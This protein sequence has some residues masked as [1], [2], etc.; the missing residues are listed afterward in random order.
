MVVDNSPTLADFYAHVVDTVASCSFQ[1][2]A[3]TN[4]LVLDP[5]CTVHPFNGASFCFKCFKSISGSR[6]EFTSML[7]DRLTAVVQK[8]R[9]MNAIKQDTQIYAYIQYGHARMNTEHSLLC[10][11][12][13]SQVGLE[14]RVSSLDLFWQNTN[15]HIT[16][17]SGYFNLIDEYT[18]Y[19]INEGKYHM[20]LIA[21]SPQ[22]RGWA[23]KIQLNTNTCRQTDSTKGTA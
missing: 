12:L 11:L 2:H 19:I 21:A 6:D 3:H 5:R 16:L 10:K 18:N 1:L 15:L 23:G 22:V 13:K 8:W 7:H 17:A 14:L 9:G 4:T 20:R